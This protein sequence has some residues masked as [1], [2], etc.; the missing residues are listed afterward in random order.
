[1][2]FFFHGVLWCRSLLGLGK[3]A[4]P[5]DLACGIQRRFAIAAAEVVG[6][7][8]TLL[9]LL[10]SIELQFVVVSAAR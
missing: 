6:F 4:R 3:V 10:L 1:L 2:F 7:R 5:Y 9:L 8:K